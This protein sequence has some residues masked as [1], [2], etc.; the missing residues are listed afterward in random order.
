M[1]WLLRKQDSDVNSSQRGMPNR[2]SQHRIGHEI[3]TRN[4]ESLANVVNNLRINCRGGVPV[5]RRPR[6]KRQ[7]GLISGD[8][9]FERNVGHFLARIVPILQKRDLEPHNGRAFELEVRIAPGSEDA[10]AKVLVTGV[11]SSKEGHFAIDDHQFAMITEVDLELSA[12]LP[13]GDEALNRDAGIPQ[14]L[15]VGAGSALSSQRCHKATNTAR[16]D[17]TP[18]SVSPEVLGRDCHHE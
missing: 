7:D 10:E 16:R 12:E 4:P 1:I 6:R 13:I 9:R 17:A 2:C 15:K 3:R 5:L 11:Q 18:R 14:F 8:A